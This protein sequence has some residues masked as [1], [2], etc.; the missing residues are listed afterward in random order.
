[1]KLYKNLFDLLKNMYQNSLELMKGSDFV[2]DYVH[3]LYFKCHKINLNRG[4]S[5]IDSP[6]WIKNKKA[7][8][9][10]INK[11]HFQ[12]AVA[13]ALNHKE[14]G[15]ILKNNNFCNVIMPSE[16]TKILEFN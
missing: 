4:G 8:I 12:Y 11:K 15:K 6:G 9:N 7:T 2:L 5:Y 16:D 14:I 10:P 1:M 13:V 3:L